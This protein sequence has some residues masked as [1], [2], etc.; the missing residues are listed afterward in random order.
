MKLGSLVFVVVALVTACSSPAPT[1]VPTPTLVLPPSTI[2]LPTAADPKPTSAAVPTL[3]VSWQRMAIT[4]ANISVETPKDWKRIGTEWAWTRP[5]VAAQ[6]VS[7]NWNTRKPGWESTS[8]LPNHSVSL[9]A[10][11]IEVMWGTGMLHTVQVSQ[12]AAQG[13][14]PTAVEAHAIVLTDK[15]AYDFS[16]SAKTAE[17]LATLQQVVQHMLDSVKMLK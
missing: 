17:E 6:S 14:K 2:P 3:A 13:G 9:D 7:I 16:A 8:M 10:Q 15:L 5:N 11:P 1:L 4:T 12:S